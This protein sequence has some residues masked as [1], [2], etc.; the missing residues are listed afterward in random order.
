MPRILL[1]V[2]FVIAACAPLAL[3]VADMVQRYPLDGAL[4]SIGLVDA[5]LL[6]AALA[7][8]LFLLTRLGVDWRT[9]PE[10]Y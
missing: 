8:P 7:L 10:E 1:N 2:F 3:L 4:K 5:L 6:I 9:G